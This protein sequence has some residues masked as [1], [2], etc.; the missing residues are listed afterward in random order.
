MPTP[1]IQE[2]WDQAVAKATDAIQDLIDIQE[3]CQEKY[4]EMSEKVQEGERGMALDAVCALDLTGAMDTLSDA[5]AIQ[6]PL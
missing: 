2:Q 5:A 3:Q 6:I 1:K 4:D